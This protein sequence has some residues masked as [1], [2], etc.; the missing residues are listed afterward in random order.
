MIRIIIFFLVQ[1]LISQSFGQNNPENLLTD[2]KNE[3]LNFGVGE[4]LTI[5]LKSRLD[6]VQIL[7]LN[8]NRIRKNCPEFGT[9]GAEYSR[10]L[11]KKNSYK[12]KEDGCV[13]VDCQFATK[14]E[15]FSNKLNICIDHI[16]KYQKPNH[17]RPVV[18]I[19]MSFKSK[20]GQLSGF[21]RVVTVITKDN[22]L[23]DRNE[24]VYEE[25]FKNEWLGKYKSDNKVNLIA[26]G[27][28][29]FPSKYFTDLDIGGGEL[30]INYKYLENGWSKT[31]SIESY[32]R[33]E[34]ENIPTSD[35]NYY[36]VESI[37]DIIQN[38]EQLSEKLDIGYGERINQLDLKCDLKEN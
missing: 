30:M 6:L 16:I 34:A 13:V 28:N 5:S 2:F 15:L 11:I 8:G 18:E 14:E 36:G 24:F 29:R 37:E 4:D 20:N 7:K 26:W 1:V 22:E 9:L 38:W 21:G 33:K 31:F 32:I 27:F 17:Q 23:L 35:Y 19:L 10:L 25:G 3:R 12:K